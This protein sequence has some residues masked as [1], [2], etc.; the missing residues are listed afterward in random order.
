MPTRRLAAA[1]LGVA[2]TA[3]LALAGCG[4][5]KNAVDQT[6]GGE[7]RYVP[8]DGKIVQYEPG[9]RPAAPDMRGELL[10]GGSYELAGHKGEVVVVNFW[11]SW[12][13]PCRA[14]AK[15][16]E[17]VYQATKPDKVSFVGVNIR[18]DRDKAKAFVRGRST[19]PSL[20]DPAGR[21]SLA[22][23]GVSIGTPCTLVI[24]RDGRIAAAFNKAVLSDELQ[25]VVGRVAGENR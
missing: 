3:V 1:T 9:K 2:L 23:T 16:L 8:G 21:Y 13:A 7:N 19:Y 17:S 12:C 18:D 10:D 22:F 20:F 4:T 14:E 5:G 24:D 15:D 6:A 25:P 11:A